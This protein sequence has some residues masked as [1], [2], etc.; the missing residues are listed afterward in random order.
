MEV[1]SKNTKIVLQNQLL[2]LWK[3]TKI[4]SWPKILLN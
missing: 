2:F 4:W 3:L 1:V